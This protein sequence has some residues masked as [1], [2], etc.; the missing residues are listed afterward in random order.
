MSH[1]LPMTL[2]SASFKNPLRRSSLDSFGFSFAFLF[3]GRFFRFEAFYYL[4]HK[5]S[6]LCAQSNA[7]G[8]AHLSSYLIGVDVGMVPEP[9]PI[10]GPL[11]ELFAGILGDRASEAHERVEYPTWGTIQ[12][13]SI[14]A[15][16]INDAV[17]L[18]Y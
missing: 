6:H 18:R 11:A 4:N 9:R 16:A 3:F 1:L 15:L 14:G 10:G 7:F 12:Y 8:A 17:P 5:I 2:T 13:T